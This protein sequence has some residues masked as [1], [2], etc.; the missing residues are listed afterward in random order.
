[1]TETE[2][3]TE[4]ELHPPVPPA[5]PSVASEPEQDALEQLDMLDRSQGFGLPSDH[6]DP[7]AM[8][9]P[10]SF[11][12]NLPLWQPDAPPAP[13]PVP[14]IRTSMASSKT[15]EDLYSRHPEIGGGEKYLRVSRIAPKTYNGHKIGGFLGDVH[16]QL[17]MSDFAAR[18]GGGT[19][20]VLV[21]GP[22]R[23]LDGDGSYNAVTLDEIKVEITGKPLAISVEDNDM[24]TTR[25]I[26][27][28]RSMRSPQVEITRMQLEQENRRRSEERNERV[29]KQLMQSQQVPQNLFQHIEEI[30][31]RRAADVRTTLQESAAATR[32]E[33]EK[34]HDRLER[35]DEEIQQLRAKMVEVQNEASMRLREEESS[36]VRELKEQHSQSMQSVKEDHSKSVERI[37]AEGQRQV[38][39]MGA[40]HT[41][42]RE[43]YERAA[44]TERDRIR[45]DARRR[46]EQLVSD[47]RLREQ[48][49]R[50]NY[51]SRLAEM[52]RSHQREIQNVKDNRDRELQ[53]I[54]MASDGNLTMSEKAAQLQIASLTNELA[55]LRVKTEAQERELYELRAAAHK[56]PVEAIGEARDLMSLVGGDKGEE[57]GEFDWRKGLFQ[58]LSR[59]GEKLPEGLE[60]LGAARAQNQ[61]SRD[62]AAARE[63]AQQIQHRRQLQ[64]AQ[65]QQID[66]RMQPQP[67]S[68]MPVQR[69]VGIPGT[70]APSWGESAGLPPEPGHANM[71]PAPHRPMPAPPAP[72]PVP[73]GSQG[74]SRPRDPVPT[75][76]EGPAST[77]FV[78]GFMS[79]APPPP[80]PAAEQDVAEASA[81][82]PKPFAQEASVPAFTQEA[83]MEFS[84]KLEMAIATGMV[85]PAEF[86]KGFIEEVGPE[87]A[88]QIIASIGPEQ[89]ADAVAAHESGKQTQIVTRAGRKYLRELWEEAKKLL[90]IEA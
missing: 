26:G 30:S 9:D 52:E 67:P 11:G 42:E 24:S 12:G 8:A 41:R 57:E 45:E 60:R 32:R 36:R 23:T 83:V 29:M 89:L 55:M 17:S 56:S 4:P 3:S 48:T 33:N 28:E 70:T 68:Q 58:V 38:N 20:Q 34:L 63:R 16:E 84:E 85:P 81:P 2:S 71:P 66:P 77:G 6:D 37:T 18:F 78:P 75:T 14:R 25:G 53:S 80:D 21:R 59:V 19:Y 13:P 86:A 62:V 1:M 27:D 15:L 49:V 69:D 22:G 43:N 35:K 51:E 5:E 54:K 76:G 74:A 61:Q 40:R 82:L 7:L 10:T 50:D 88:A 79:E 47:S 64:A 31:E 39:E 72:S 87:T 44:Q 65:Q 46:E 73:S 90:G